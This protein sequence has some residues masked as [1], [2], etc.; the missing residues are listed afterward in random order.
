M[1]KLTLRECP[2]ALPIFAVLIFAVLICA[3]LI[4]SMASSISAETKD[5]LD[6]GIAAAAGKTP[7]FVR[8]SDQLLGG[9]MGYAAFCEKNAKRDRRELRKEVLKTLQDKAKSSWAKVAETVKKLQSDGSISQLQQYWIVNGFACRADAAACKSLAKLA[10]VSFVYR[11]RMPQAAP[12]HK[13]RVRAV[14]PRIEQNWKNVYQQVIKDWKDDSKDP[15]VLDGCQIPWNVKRIKAD[16]AWTKEGATGKG[17]VVALCDSGLMVTPS[18]VQALWRNPKEKLNGKDDDN[19]GFVDDLFG[20]D[21]NRN[22]W[23]ALGDGPR[24]T[25]GSMCGGI[26]AGRSLNKKKLLTGIA[27]RARLMM[28]RGMGFL[29]QLEY[30]AD[31]GADVVSMSYMWVGRQLGH[32]RGLYRL[33]HE[34]LTVAGVVSVGGAG[35]FG[36]GARRRRQPRGRQIALPKDIPCVI[37]ASGILKNGKLAPASSEG[38]CFWNSVKFYN[39]FGKKKPL[40][41]PDVT[42]CFGGYPVWGRPMLARRIQSWRVVTQESQAIGLVIGPQGNS[43][44]GPHAAGVAALMFSAN[45]ALNAWEL[46]T[47]MQK[48]CTDLGEKGHDTKFGAGLLNAL[49]AVQL[50]KKRGG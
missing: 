50:A 10:E 41:K 48:G 7:V 31:H 24:I 1:T 47:L 16:Q 13:R 8:M 3:S 49:K 28:L 4:G 12:L 33:A 14:P 38:P 29:R 27:P 46:K 19:N 45:P 17:V 18:L 20:F 9:A 21:F 43:F 36:P 34:H 37:A 40:N 22:H 26:V 15:L 5:K 42:A 23:Y 2:C 39:D 30:A 35:N 32:Y 25:H 11:Q 44:S 6:V